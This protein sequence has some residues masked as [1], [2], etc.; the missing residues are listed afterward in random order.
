MAI[1]TVVGNFIATTSQNLEN[2]EIIKGQLI[3]VK[4][5]REFYLD[6]EGK[7]IPYQ[8]IVI[9]ETEDDRLDMLD[10][11]EGFY[12]VQETNILWSYLDERWIKVGGAG[13][14][15]IRPED[16]NIY[17]TDEIVVGT[18]IDGKP[19]YRKVVDLGTFPN[20]AEKTVAHNIANI[21][22]ITKIYTFGRLSNGLTISLGYY[23]V[24]APANSITI[25]CNKTNVAITTKNDR[26]AYTGYT[27]LEYTKT[28]N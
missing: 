23:D 13:G 24:T 21:D 4:D 25:M 8:S 10:P 12:Y 28:T 18:W 20:N 6:L 14:G 19:L 15:S 7:R 26:S 5:K 17:S 16:N 1:N 2:I 27:I 22:V 3:F 9:L 11:V